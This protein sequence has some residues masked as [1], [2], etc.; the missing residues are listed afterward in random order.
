MRTQII[1]H[2][3]QAHEM[4]SRQPADIGHAKIIEMVLNELKNESYTGA[5]LPMPSRMFKSLSSNVPYHHVPSNNVLTCYLV[6]TDFFKQFGF[7]DNVLISADRT[8]LQIASAAMNY[9]LDITNM[10]SG[11]AISPRI[12][13]TIDLQCEII[14]QRIK[15]LIPQFMAELFSR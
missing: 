8:K 13:K 2:L 6:R 11:W 12:P 4:L 15:E 5:V 7:G 9:E 3:E 1:H 14:S 10:N